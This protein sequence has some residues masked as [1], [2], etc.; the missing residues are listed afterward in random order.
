[1]Q[2]TAR[3]ARFAFALAAALAAVVV[4]A[5]PAQAASACATAIIEDW[6]NGTLAAPYPLDCYDA[7]IDAL[8]E[9]LRAYTTAAD[10][11]S[12]AAIDASRADGSTRQLA[13]T[14]ATAQSARAFPLTVVLLGGFV[15]LLAASGLAASLLR[16][17]RAG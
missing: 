5:V 12:R 17:R 1:L 3:T 16:R 13:S 2:R 10:D 11:I 14:P 7:A 6:A 4:W 8:P 9:D 15:A